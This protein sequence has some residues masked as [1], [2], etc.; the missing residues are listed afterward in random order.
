MATIMI[1]LMKLHLTYFLDNMRISL[2]FSVFKIGN[3]LVDF[4][5]KMPHQSINI[6]CHFRSLEKN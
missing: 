5:Y 2:L 1:L 4:Q 6:I 3:K